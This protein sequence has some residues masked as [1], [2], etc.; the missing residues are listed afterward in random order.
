MIEPEPADPRRAIYVKVY[1]Y[2]LLLLGLVA[3]SVWGVFLLLSLSLRHEPKHRGNIRVFNIC[4]SPELE[5]RGK[6]LYAWNRPVLTA[7]GHSQLRLVECAD[8]LPEV[9]P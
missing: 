8:D 5:V 7:A 1:P 6:T 2:L 4:T 3:L 9:T